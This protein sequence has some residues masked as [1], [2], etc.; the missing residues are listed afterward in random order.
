MVARRA[1]L[2]AAGGFDEALE[3][4]EDQHMWIK[5]A[6]SGEVGFSGEVL[7][8]KHETSGSLMEPYGGGADEFILP[9][10]RQHLSRL[11]PHLSRQEV[12]KSSESDTPP[13][14]RNIY[15]RVRL[16]ARCHSPGGIARQ[17]TTAKPRL[18]GVAARVV[19][20]IKQ[21]FVQ[22]RLRPPRTG[23][24]AHDPGMVPFGNPSQ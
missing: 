10:I 16:R 13:R 4:S 17:P 2:L 9:M 19:A 15:A 11:A 7:V 8:R 20:L 12:K 18:S 23:S 3:I 22:L 21:R 14:G 5:L 6:L 1:K 24:R